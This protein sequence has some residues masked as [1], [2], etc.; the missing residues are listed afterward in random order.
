MVWNVRQLVVQKIKKNPGKTKTSSKSINL[1][2][3]EHVRLYKINA[4]KRQIAILSMRPQENLDI[5]KKYKIK[6]FIDKNN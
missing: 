2:A 5:W 4:E 3:E 1:K 6:I